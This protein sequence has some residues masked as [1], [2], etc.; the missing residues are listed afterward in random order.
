MGLLFSKLVYNNIYK[1]REV[2]NMVTFGERIR[3]L[4]NELGK[5][6]QD[7]AKDLGLTKSQLSHY[8]NGRRKVPSELLQKIVD[9]YNISPL[10]LFRETEQLYEVVKEEKEAY[11]TKSEYKYFPA[12]VSAG[13]PN[14]V[15][16]ITEYET[17]SIA[18][19]IMGKYANSKDI[20][21]IKINGESMNKVIPHNSLVAVRPVS[22]VHDLKNGDIVVYRKDG[23]YAVKRYIKQPDKVIFR[24]E[25][26]DNSFTDDVVKNENLDS[27]TIKG[28]VVL[29]IVE[30]D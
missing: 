20:Y 14:D 15:E 8:I 16:A 11:T 12:Y 30:L 27:V 6:E 19:K 18:D 28:K 24:P 29:Y 26:N 9:T 21:F 10:F 13:L 2:M 4:A 23:E 17:I 25:S 3:K 22:T 7:L 5:E 1:E